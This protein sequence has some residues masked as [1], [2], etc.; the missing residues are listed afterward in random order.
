M[1]LDHHILCVGEGSCLTG[2]EYFIEKCK[3][4]EVKRGGRLDGYVIYF[5]IYIRLA[6]PFFGGRV[7]RLSRLRKIV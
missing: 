6:K 7:L 2:T 5:S 3:G 1:A 4:Q